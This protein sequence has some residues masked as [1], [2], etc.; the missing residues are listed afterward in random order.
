MDVL[1]VGTGSGYSA[2]LLCHRFGDRRVSSVD[3]DPCLTGAARGWLAAAGHHPEVATVDATSQLSGTYDRIIATV[4]V[5]RI[6]ASWLTALRPGG[7]LTDHRRG[8]DAGRRRG[9]PRRTG[10]GRFP[11]C[12]SRPRLP[13]P[14]H[15]PALPRAQPGRGR[16]HH[17][18]VSRPFRR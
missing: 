18:S 2:A 11:E 10:L 6:P 3:V 15:D 9:R 5:P 1:D 8:Q 4:S 16:G 14:P 17:R 12:P 13:A 7:H